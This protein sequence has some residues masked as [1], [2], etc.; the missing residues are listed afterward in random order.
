M[1]KKIR[2]C[3]QCGDFNFDLLQIDTGNFT[4]YFFNLLC[5]YGLLPHVLQAT[6]AAVNTAPIIDNIF[7]NNLQDD[8]ISGNLLLTLPEHF[9]Q[10]ISVNREVIDLTKINVYER[11]FK[12]F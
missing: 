8:I 11:L 2:K 6:R 7:S 9:A 10:F 4:R 12:V 1:Q 3:I 5:S